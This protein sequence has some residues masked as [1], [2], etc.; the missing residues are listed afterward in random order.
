MPPESEPTELNKMKTFVYFVGLLV[1][2]AYA[3]SA[4]I[5]AATHVVVLKAEDARR[6]DKTLA[7]LLKSPNEQIRVRAALAAGRIGNDG[8]VPV[9]SNLLEK[10]PSSRVR[11]MAAFA[12]GEIE[13]VKGA[14][15]ILKSLGAVTRPDGRPSV[16][17]VGAR[18]VEAAGKIAAANPTDAKAFDLREAIL[19]VLESEE[20][21]GNKQDRE[22]VLLALTAALRAAPRDAKRDRPDDTDIIV[23]KF[24]TNLDARVRSDAANT[25]TRVRAKNA[26]SMGDRA[27]DGKLSRLRPVTWGGWARTSGPCVRWL[28][29][30]RMSRCSS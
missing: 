17:N 21:K 3:A 20:R 19:E 30:P 15:V 1:L 13:S 11:Q 18:L 16:S 27:D 2:A 28:L 6:Y 26:A 8:A 7:D 14:D 22:T 5:P 29:L 25:L 24:L 10:D 23:A 9:L 12:L 4:Q